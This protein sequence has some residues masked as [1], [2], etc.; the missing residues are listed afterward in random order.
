MDKLE[1]R[2]YAINQR[3]KW[4]KEYPIHNGHYDLSFSIEGYQDGLTF[5]LTGEEL[6]TIINRNIKDMEEELTGL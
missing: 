2:K 3:L 1:R 4:L 5:K 6:V